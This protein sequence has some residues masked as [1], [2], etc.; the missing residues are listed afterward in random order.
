MEARTDTMPSLPDWEAPPPSSPT[1][2]L[3][4]A[5]AAWILLAVLAVLLVEA[6]GGPGLVG[7]ALIVIV[8]ATDL[9]T[10][11]RRALRDRSAH[12]LAEGSSPRV[13]NVFRGIEEK[14]G[15]A[16]AR[17]FVF[18][19]PDAEAFVCHS[20]APTVALSQG[21]LDTFSRTEMEA[22]I[23]HCLLRLRSTG[24]RRA[25]LACHL[26][27][28]APVVGTVV[29]PHEDVSSV[30]LTRYP[31]TLV[32][33]LQRCREARGHRAPLYL[34]ARHPCHVP[35]DDRIAALADL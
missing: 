20:G 6:V 27:W 15:L 29:G 22:V 12:V 16:D 33:A 32:S 14:L 8:L 10:Q 23:A 18:P 2:G 35:R 28:L 34:A 5:G 25:E 30:A 4:T 1:A 26:R 17:L 13:E 19:S 11:G 31:P 7:A 21:L 3:A 24:V 9:L